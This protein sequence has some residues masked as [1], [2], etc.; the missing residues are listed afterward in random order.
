[1]NPLYN[2][3]KDTQGFASK[4]LESA[5]AE[6]DR[7]DFV[8]EEFKNM[9]YADFPLPLGWNVTISQPSTVLFMLNLLEPRPGEKILDVGA[10][11]G[12]TTALLSSAVGNTGKVFGVE[13]VPELVEM[14][15]TN[16][17]KYDLPYTTIKLAGNELGLPKKAPFDKILVSA[18]GKD[19]SW[20][21]ISQLKPGGGAV[22][23]IGSSIWKI[24]KVS[25]K[26]IKKTEYPGFAFVPLQT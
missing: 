23:P 4:E 24:D 8:P 21:L 14:G 19:L 17:K 26:E 10:G 25:D 5:F 11:S 1:M 6:I 18:S 12:W 20:E 2:Y 15:R 3:L 16:L 7:A 13:I 22:I 9:A